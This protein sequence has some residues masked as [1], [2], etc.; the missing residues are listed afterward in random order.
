MNIVL[1]GKDLKGLFSTVKTELASLSELTLSI[2]Q[3]ND[4]TFTL[5]ACHEVPIITIM[6]Y[7]GAHL[8]NKL[9]FKEHIAKIFEKI[10]RY[11][12]IFYHVRHFLPRKRLRFLYFSFVY[13]YLYYCAAETCQIPLSNHFNLS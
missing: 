7:L 2:S 8:D 11:I 5:F 12:K 4:T 3:D 6:K 1:F 10:K 9:T 13:S